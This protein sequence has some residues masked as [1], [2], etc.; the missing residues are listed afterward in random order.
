MSA[1]KDCVELA[2][3]FDDE[4]FIEVCE[5]ERSLIEERRRRA[6]VAAAADKHNLVGVA[7]SGGGIR[8][9]AFCVGVLQSLTRSGFLRRFVDYLSTVSGGSY[10]GAFFSSTVVSQAR[11]DDVAERQAGGDP[12]SKVATFAETL[13]NP[14]DHGGNARPNAALRRLM[15]RAN[16]QRQT[17]VALSRYLFGLAATLG[18]GLSGLI[19]FAS[20]AAFLARVVHYHAVGFLMEP[21]GV[22]NDISTALLPS[23][24]LFALWILAWL[25][26]LLRFG[27]KSSGGDARLWFV[28]LIG[29]LA[30][31]LALLIG[32]GDINI[33]NIAY[34]FG[35]EDAKP[36][37]VGL[38]TV[39]TAFVAFVAASLIPYFVPRRLIRSGTRPQS[40][41]EKLAFAS[42][43]F[44]GA[45]GVPLIAIGFLAQEDISRFNER[46][47]SAIH[48]R[49]EIAEWVE[50][51]VPPLYSELLNYS[52]LSRD[53]TPSD[54]SDQPTAAWPLR[55]NSDEGEAD[56][57]RDQPLAQRLSQ[58]IDA[59]LCRDG[60]PW[61]LA[62][63]FERHAA[64]Y[65]NYEAAKQGLTFPKGWA[66]LAMLPF[67][68]WLLANSSPTPSETH[69]KERSVERTKRD[70]T[71]WYGYPLVNH[72]LRDGAHEWGRNELDDALLLRYLIYYARYEMAGAFN[73]CLLRPSLYQE[74]TP[75]TLAEEGAAKEFENT[76]Q[77]AETLAKALNR[78]MKKLPKDGARPQ[79]KR[80][81]VQYA[82]TQ[83]KAP[84]GGEGGAPCRCRDRAE[85]RSPKCDKTSLQ[86]LLRF[87]ADDRTVVGETYR[88]LVEVNRQ[89]V[90]LRF[91]GALRD[92]ST[93]FSFIVHDHDQAFR[94]EMFLKFGAVFLVLSAV[95][96]LDATSLDWFYSQRLSEAWVQRVPGFSDKLPLAQLRTTE[97]GYP[98]HLISGAVKLP[99]L[100]DPDRSDLSTDHFLLSQHYCGSS[101]T[102]YARTAAYMEGEP[103]SLEDA[104]AISGGA[105]SPQHFDNVLSR[106]IFFVL[107][108]RLGRY[109]ENPG[110]RKEALWKPLRKFMRRRYWVSPL[111]VGLSSLQRA[112]RRPY[113][114]VADGGFY[115]NTGVAELIRR[116]CR[117]VIAV[118]A[119]ADPK[120]DFSD[121][122]KMLQLIRLKYGVRIRPLHGASEALRLGDLVTPTVPKDESGGASNDSERN[123]DKNERDARYYAKR[124]FV[125]AKIDYG[126]ASQTD[127][128]MVL[129]RCSMDG[130]EPQEIV[131]RR[132][133]FP[134]FPNDSTFDQ[135]FD[136]SQFEAYRLL[137]EHIG[138]DL[139]CRLSK[140]LPSGIAQADFPTLLKALEQL[141]IDLSGEAGGDGSQPDKRRP[142]PHS[143]RRRA[144]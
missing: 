130:D 7:L 98:I 57:R 12:L 144:D 20:L 41:W 89:L 85:F 101:V 59:G 71:N 27:R 118:D 68:R 72:E 83:I 28:L 79:P 69:G 114:F 81:C 102:T 82:W 125:V 110:W 19:A 16:Y 111:V 43:I 61:T 132:K 15:H 80:N 9:G 48:A 18:L 127:G 13:D 141:E 84:V 62:D 70:L 66:S 117:L 86:T 32:N 100:R 51:P 74:F 103:P 124:H 97:S 34:L 76:L 129:V 60:I 140:S 36:S 26:S 17:P 42:A 93:V 88:E 136:A 23:M 55:A 134:A 53:Q 2:A 40:I 87:V 3:E 4:P 56:P 77:R 96:G 63:G 94:W 8:S 54:Y 120:G 126:A 52:A 116:R 14:C 5:K 142:A 123:F 115:D 113:C 112:D 139:M 64:I 105:L 137:G 78:E 11:R 22:D 6:G 73:Y 46:R 37:G 119:G 24:V 45:A 30:I 122:A 31:A 58:I 90:S 107:N 99:G 109:L 50:R 75:E 131:Q 39:G 92:K 104:I 44:A 143:A 108:L 95:I 25:L 138:G 21:L 38:Q 1:H 67:D 29:S 106:I 10:A 65:R 33:A 135:F 91:P 128:V 49:S 47:T 121:F 35:G 133:M